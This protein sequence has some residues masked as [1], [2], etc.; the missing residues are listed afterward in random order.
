[1]LRQEWEVVAATAPPG[2]AIFWARS[3]RRG[4]LRF[5]ETEAMGYIFEP[6]I[7]QQVAKDVISKNLPIE[8]LVTT[9]V[10]ELGKRYPNHIN[11]SPAWVFNNAG[12]AMGAMCFLH[13]SLTEY[14]MIFG[15]PLGTEGHSGRFLVDD[16]FVILA[17]EQWAF[18]AGQFVR[19]VYRPGDMHQLARG[20]A[21][22]YKI[23]EMCWALEYA[24]G[25]IP[26]MVPFGL[27]DTL[28][29]TLDFH[30]LAHSVWIYTKSAAKELL[31]G[32]I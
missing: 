14:L 26:T 20:R 21:K 31:R 6:G 7:L 19:E 9:I 4:L 30:T 18:S 16:Y 22:Q 25:L 23:P 12:G 29:S 5:G 24:R 11:T 17:G 15:T 13:A 8:D 27:A 28:T 1:M 10:T 3:P 2:I 32:K